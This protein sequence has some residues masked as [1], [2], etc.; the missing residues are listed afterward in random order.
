[1]E[2]IEAELAEHPKTAPPIAAE[3]ALTTLALRILAL[4]KPIKAQIAQSLQAVDRTNGSLETL[5][6]THR[7]RFDIVERV[8]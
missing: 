6:P 8:P 2:E 3:E 7:S 5:L 1:V 4:T